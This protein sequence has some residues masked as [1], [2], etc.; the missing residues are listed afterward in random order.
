VSPV[1]DE[2]IASDQN[3]V[4]A[5]GHLAASGVLLRSRLFFILLALLAPRL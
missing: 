4:S 2:A 1:R 5:A 3:V